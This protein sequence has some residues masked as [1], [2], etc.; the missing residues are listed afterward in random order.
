MADFVND[1]ASES[2]RDEDDTGSDASEPAAK[3]Q[4]KQKKHKRNKKI[5]SDEEDEEDEAAEDALRSEEMKGF[6]VDED[7]DD[8]EGEDNRDDDQSDRANS[9]EDD[10]LDDDLDLLDENIGRKK[11]GRVEMDSD[12]EDDRERIKNDIFDQEDEDGAEEERR[13]QAPREYEDDEEASRSESEQSE[14]QF[15]VNDDGMDRKRTKGK[16]GRMNNEFLNDAKDVFGVEDIDE[17]YDDEEGI[18]DEAEEGEE[19]LSSAKPRTTK[20]SLWNSIEPS[21]LDKG[22]VSAADKRIIF[23]DRPERF[24]MRKI[25]VTEVDD[26]ELD[27]ET[28]WVHEYAF[29]ADTIS[30]QQGIGL[31]I[32]SGPDQVATY[33]G[34]MEAPDKIKEAIRF[35]RNQHFEVPFI[36]F[37]RKEYVESSLHM[38]DLWKVYQYDEKWCRLQQR[39]QRVLELLKRVQQYIVNCEGTENIRKVTEKDFND[40]TGVQTTEELADVYAHFQLY[41]GSEM[42]RVH[43]WE[44]NVAK[45]KLD[46]TFVPKFKLCG[47]TD[48]Y[49]LCIQCGLGPMAQKFGLTP[50]EFSENFTEYVKHEVRQDPLE[51]NEVAKEL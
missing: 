26:H 17:F 35:I 29:K 43:E 5:S 41:Y 6:V 19:G 8:D 3:R 51:P 50:E 21:E 9:D 4:K 13:R 48:K 10:L 1:Q 47:R 15:I 38:S 39:K 14:G 22:F 12:D 24:Q 16:K 32:L 25:P 49:L 44:Q 42:S 27:L 40:V 45:E 36:A 2:D 11:G 18:E 23:E 28:A 33:K 34:E 30:K 37:Y 20:V 46:S 7:E 31:S